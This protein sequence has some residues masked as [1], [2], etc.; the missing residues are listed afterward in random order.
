MVVK[1][2][3]YL[4]E[5]KAHDDQDFFVKEE[6]EEGVFVVISCDIVY[7]NADMLTKP[8]QSNRMLMLMSNMGMERADE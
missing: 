8:T 5:N 6:V 4:C 1:S 2:G 7:M 3:H